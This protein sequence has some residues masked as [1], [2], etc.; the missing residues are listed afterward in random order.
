[1]EFCI[2]NYVHFEGEILQSLKDN[3]VEH[4]IKAS[5]GL[6]LGPLVGL[7]AILTLLQEDASYSEI[8]LIVGL[9]GIGLVV[10]SICLYL[11]LAIE[12][13]T[14]RDF[15]VA[16]FLP[17]IITSLSY[18]LVANKGLLV[19]T[20]WGLGVATLG[21]WGVP[22]LMSTFPRCFT[23]GEATAVMHACVLFLISVAT[24][25]PLR[26]HLPPIHDEDIATVLIQIAMLYAISVCLISGYFPIFHMTK[27]FYAITVSLLLIVVLPLMYVLLDQNP[28]TWM[29][30]FILGE[31]NKIILILYWTICLSLSVAVL[32]YQVLL[33]LQATTATRKVFHVL[34]VLVY[35]PGLLYDRV[36][37]YLASGVII[38]LFI[39]LELLRY[40]RIPP[41]GGMLQQGFSAFVD[42]KDSS[43]SLT[44]L[45]LFCGLSFPLWM[46]TNNLSLLVMLSGVLIIGVGDTAASCVGS[47]WGSRKWA[48]DLDKSVEGT[49]A[50]ILSQVGLICLL[51]FMGHVGT[52]PLFVRSLVASVALSFVEARTNQVDN[53]ALPLLMYVC[54]MV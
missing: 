17:A 29:F 27:N 40:L 30:Y 26:Y 12:K 44:P 19:S 3:G 51:A 52:G 54:L 47:R 4:R 10:S 34:A 8:C 7:S 32:M 53:L 42:E 38:V 31:T 50:C 14:V 11:R 21:T 9:T 15:Q 36:L 43:I 46:P 24:N 28:V 48:A 22:Q 39:L 37:L 6:W 35:I 1:M 18:L 23:I 25:L 33:K 20:T 41:M 13:I 16:Y 2:K 5:S 49:I 45:Y